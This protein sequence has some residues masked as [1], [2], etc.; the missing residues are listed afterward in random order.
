MRTLLEVT[1]AA[2]RAAVS[3]TNFELL[4]AA[5]FQQRPTE[6]DGEPNDIIGPPE[7][8]DWEEYDL[9]VD[10]LLAVFRCTAAG[11]PGTWVQIKPAIAADTFAGAPDNYLVIVPTQQWKQYYWHDVVAAWKPVFLTP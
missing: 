7:D 8:G 11:T 3:Q 9:W 1:N 4:D 5:V 2:D 6:V 10:S